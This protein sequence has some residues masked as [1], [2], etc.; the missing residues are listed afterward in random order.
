MEER[1]HTSSARGAFV[2]LFQMAM[3][4]TAF[5]SVGRRSCRRP[6][7][8]AILSWAWYTYTIEMG[9]FCE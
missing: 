5:A 8:V 1:S 6:I 7:A 9:R 4:E 3:R 2:F